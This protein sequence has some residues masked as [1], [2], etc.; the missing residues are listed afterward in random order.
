MTEHVMID[1]ETLGTNPDSVF[2][3]VAGVFFDINTGKCGQE[4]Y[5]NVTKQSAINAGRTVS[6]STMEWWAKQDPKIMARMY[7][8]AKPLE[9]VLTKFREFIKLSPTGVTPWGNSA[10]FDLGMLN[11]AYRRAGSGAPWSFMKERCY[12]TIVSELGTRI[13]FPEPSKQAHDPIVDCKYQI[14]KLCMV[15]QRLKNV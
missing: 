3:S 6:T 15:W 7:V 11:D 5:M 2:L 9:I 14:K 12:R 8:N 10:S 1:L 4:F 13:V